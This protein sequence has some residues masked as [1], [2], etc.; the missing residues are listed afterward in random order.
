[1]K[2]LKQIKMGKTRTTGSSLNEVLHVVGPA[3]YS[4]IIQTQHFFHLSICLKIHLIQ[5]LH[6]PKFIHAGQAVRRTYNGQPARYSETHQIQYFFHPSI[7]L[8]IHLIQILP[9]SKF[10]HAGEALRRTTYNGQLARYSETRQRQL[11][12]QLPAIPSHPLLPF[13]LYA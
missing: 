6:I 11:Y 10:I 2:V 5:I 7:F 13:F 9:I 12:L 8:K 1:M 4:E 3:R